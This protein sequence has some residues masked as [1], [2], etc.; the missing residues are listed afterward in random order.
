MIDFSCKCVLHIQGKVESEQGGL[1][2]LL[3]KNEEL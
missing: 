2:K 1:K 3:H